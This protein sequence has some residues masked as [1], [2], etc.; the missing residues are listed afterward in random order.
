M[1]H[2]PREIVALLGEHRERQV[3][4]QATAT[5]WACLD[6]VFCTRYGTYLTPTTI[7]QRFG[8]LLQAAGLAHMKFHALRHNAS[9]F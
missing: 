7:Q 6:L 8:R 5:R 3:Q 9:L 1:I 4:Q 2:L